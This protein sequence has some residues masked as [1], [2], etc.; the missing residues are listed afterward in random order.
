[1]YQF[2]P[3]YHLI[4]QGNHNMA[5]K[6]VSVLV[7]VYHLILQGNHNTILVILYLAVPVYHLILQ[8]NHN[9]WV[10]WLIVI[11]LFIISFCKGITTTCHLFEIFYLLFKTEFLLI[12]F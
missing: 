3:V 6:Y 5:S 10:L 2:P 9:C 11:R 12:I 4:L 7:P 1:M 8:G